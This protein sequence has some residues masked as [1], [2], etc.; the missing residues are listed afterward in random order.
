M[1]KLH[2]INSIYIMLKVNPFSKS[3]AHFYIII[4]IITF[5]CIAL[6][7]TGLQS[8]SQNRIKHNKKKS[9]T[10]KRCKRIQ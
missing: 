5:I 10:K 7:E 2:V 3:A 1:L 6:F 9:H 8:V 4:I